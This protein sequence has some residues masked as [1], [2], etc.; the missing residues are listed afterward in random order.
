MEEKKCLTRSPRVL[1]LTNNNGYLCGRILADLGADVIKIEK[2][3]G[4]PDRRIGPFYHQTPAPERSLVWLAYNANKRGI[5]LKLDSKEGQQILR[6]LANNAD[7]LIE[8]FAPGSM[9]ELGL[10]YANL[11]QL[12]PRM[13]YTSIS[14]FGQTGPYKN[15]KASDLVVMAMS[16]LLYITGKP[17]APP[18]RISFPQSFLLASAH[19]AAASLIAYFYREKTGQGQYVDVSAQE[20]VL[21]ELSNAVPL[22]ELNHK[23]L[24]RAGSYLSGRWT[25]TKQKLLWRCKD[26][27]VIF[28]ILG[29]D[30]GLKTNRAIAAWLREEGL[31]SEL[32]ANFDWTKFDMSSQTQ[33]MQEQME[34]PIAELFLK[35][36]KAA[37]YGQA[38]KRKIMLCPVSTA[39]DI[40]ENTQLDARN[41]WAKVD[42]PEI[43]AQITYP[44]PFAKLS[45]TAL[46]RL[47]KAPLPGEHNL[48]IYEK[49]L[50]FSKRERVLLQQSGII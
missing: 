11:H 29:G 40:F 37:L 22:W 16:G 45:E 8:S 3:G 50:G 39:R 26:G 18:V 19:A 12:N 42:Y 17:D 20:C 24:K 30:F 10:G 4:D 23:I 49:E 44:G 33:E 38:L 14:P 34:A 47:K 15:F 9:D 2:P 46:T 13:I 35:Y 5:T 41:F 6:A 28:Y 36:T 48:E 7:F 32:M 1:D 21:W 43:P 25:D 31:A 27:Y